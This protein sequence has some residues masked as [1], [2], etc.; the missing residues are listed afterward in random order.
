MKSPLRL[1]RERRRLTLKQVADA[2]AMDPGNLSR[3]ERGE[4]VPSKELLAALVKFFGNLVTELQI[5]YP[6]RF[7]SETVK[8]EQAAQDRR[9][10]RERRRFAERRAAERKS[11]AQVAP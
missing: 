6:E 4:Q 1:A 7:D 9:T 5:I 2:V 10:L 8:V 3:V 11:T